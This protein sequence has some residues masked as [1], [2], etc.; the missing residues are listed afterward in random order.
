MR[1][2]ERVRV[3]LGLG[4]KGIGGSKAG[5]WNPCVPALF[6]IILIFVKKKY[7]LN[8]IFIFFYYL[9]YIL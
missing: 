6:F 3:G 5:T 8:C 2:Q 9:F 7:L 4:M 1:A